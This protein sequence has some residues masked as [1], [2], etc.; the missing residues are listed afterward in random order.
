MVFFLISKQCVEYNERIEISKCLPLT[1]SLVSC[2][3]DSE[4]AIVTK[5]YFSGLENYGADRE[6]LLSINMQRAV[7]VSEEQ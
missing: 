7:D 3:N 6:G 5:C 2:A 4:P 1:S